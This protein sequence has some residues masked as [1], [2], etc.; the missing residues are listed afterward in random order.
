MRKC[1]LCGKYPVDGDN[2]R[3]IVTPAEIVMLVCEKCL[4]ECEHNRGF[5]NF[6]CC[7]AVI[8]RHREEERL[9]E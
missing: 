1:T 8:N 7:I 9:N 3:V 5:E 4:N 6:K 2:S